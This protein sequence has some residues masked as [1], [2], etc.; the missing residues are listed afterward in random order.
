MHLPALRTRL[1]LLPAAAHLAPYFALHPATANTYRQYSALPPDIPV[2]YYNVSVMLPT[3]AYRR[4]LT[5][6]RNRTHNAADILQGDDDL[7]PLARHA[8]LPPRVSTLFTAP[9]IELMT[10]SCLLPV[11]YFDMSR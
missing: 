4:Q 6:L 2:A 5:R 10:V 1:L 8:L 11:S 3:C 7:P 9:L